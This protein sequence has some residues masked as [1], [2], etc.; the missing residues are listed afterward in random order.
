MLPLLFEVCIEEGL[1][2]A[3]WS[4]ANSFL[5]L[6][7]VFAAF[8][9][10]LMGHYFETTAHYGGAQYIPTGRGLATAREPFVKSFRT[11]AV[12][13]MQDGLELALFLGFGFGV[14]F[15]WAFYLCMSFTV[16]SWMGAPFLF[17]PHQFDSISQA[18]KDCS[19]WLKWLGCSTGCDAESWVAWVD[20]EQ[21]VRRSSS[22]IWVFVPSWRF[23]GL[24][25]STALVL[26]TAPLPAFVPT[27]AWAR[28]LLAILP[29][30]AHALLCLLWVPVTWCTA[31][32]S[33]ASSSHVLLAALAVAITCFEMSMP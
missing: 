20:K 9:S 31:S 24:A 19:E 29:P 26:W 8:Q 32:L 14:P 2:A 22:M 10:K 30:L 13:N 12:S 15:G 28:S 16:V 3:M 25:C 1:R 4:V 33:P 18:T 23:W 27:W 7:P 17:N 11:F 5:S 21:N 6:S